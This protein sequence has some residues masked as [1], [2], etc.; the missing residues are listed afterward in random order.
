MARLHIHKIYS[1]QNFS[2][3]SIPFVREQ[4]CVLSPSS[5]RNPSP[6]IKL[7]RSRKAT[8]LLYMQGLCTALVCIIGYLSMRIP[9][10][11]KW[12]FQQLVKWSNAHPDTNCFTSYAI[13]Q[14]VLSISVIWLK[15]VPTISGWSKKN[16]SKS[17]F[18]CD[19]NNQQQSSAAQQLPH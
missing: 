2:F 6:F 13:T 17:G 4:L 1:N 19:H 7:C 8:A 15:N 3:K 18:R 10:N 14:A 12:D 5:G 9:H 11:I 16:R